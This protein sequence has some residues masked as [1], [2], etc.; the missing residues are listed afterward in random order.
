MANVKILNEKFKY[1]I[2]NIFHLFYDEIHFV[3]DDKYDYNVIVG[4][5]S[6]KILHNDL[7]E[8]FKFEDKLT[9]KENVKKILYKFLS[10]DVNIE[11]PWG[12]LVGI[13][14]TKIAL[15]LMKDGKTKEEV[16]EYFA[17]HSLTREDKIKLCIDVAEK[18]ENFVNKDN[19]S[20]SVYIGMPFCPTRCLYC[21]FISDTIQNCKGIVD[22]YLQAMYYEMENIYK[23]IKSKNLNI[24]CVYFGG[25]TPTSINNKQFE[26][27]MFRI[28]NSF[29]KGNN[30]RE[31]T[32]ECGRPDS[33]TREK[34]NTLKKYGVH[35][36]S[37]NPQTM[38][39]A[40]L[41]LIGRGHNSKDI[42]D[43]F[44]LARSLGFDNINVD[45]IVG[46]PGEGLEEV[47][48][49]C[50]EILQLSPDSLTVHGMSLKRG[51]K[52][53]QNILNN[54]HMKIAPQDE[55]NEMYDETVKL[56][57]DL[58]LKPYYMYRQKNMVGNMENIGYSKIGRE[59][60]YNIEM[61]E[62]R[63]TIIAIGAN[64][65]SKTIF[66]EENRL[67]RF[68]NVKDVREYIKRI[69]EKVQS[70]IKFLNELY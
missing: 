1:E 27:T 25:G 42:I 28:Y 5:Y 43:K 41:K 36:I 45:I 64:A 4:D 53:H 14:P 33:I 62:E 6:I 10:K 15:K 59:C 61:I 70:K 46:L 26:E 19:N 7:C 21:S 60:I 11:L 29:I 39:D 32:V 24:E 16:K 37:I 17:K 12:T 68:P 51:S 18:E 3:N 49:T 54:I 30:V 65:V 57:K 55:L 34:L 67:E 47:K 66:L 69:E 38:N 35:R 63:Q 31:F 52:L 23:Y 2:Y 44:N 8:D 13:R 22:D 50:S 20:V 9:S 58:K 56:S 40:T 48:Y